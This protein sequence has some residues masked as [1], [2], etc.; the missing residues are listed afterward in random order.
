LGGGWAG[1]GGGAAAPAAPHD[2]FVHPEPGTS[3]VDHLASGLIPIASALAAG[4][5]YPR[6]R[7]GLRACI[8]LMLGALALDAGIVD[9]SERWR[10]TLP[11]V[12]T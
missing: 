4:V 7:A 5:A 6:L 9:G 2:A 3:A 1:G 12:T 8:A 10:S 11:R